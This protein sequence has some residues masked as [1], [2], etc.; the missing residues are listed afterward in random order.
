[1]RPIRLAM[2]A[3]GPYASKIELNLEQLGTGGLY[4]ITGDTGAGKTTIFDA[5]TF[6]LYGEASGENREASML[7]SKYAQPGTPTEVE[8]T[9]SY[10]GKEY[11]VKR[12]PEYERP[13]ARGEGFTS[14]K[15]DARFRYPDGRMV[16]GL[17]D[18]NR[19]VLQTLGIDRAQFT[20]IAMI[21]QGDFLKLLFASTED[22]K[23]IFQK[24][25]RTERYHTL[26]ERLKDESGQLKRERDDLAN[27]IGQYM[28]DIR[29]DGDEPLSRR[30]AGEKAFVSAEGIREILALLKELI[31]RDQERDEA[32]EK[33]IGQLD[34]RI[35][36]NTA[37][38]ARAQAWAS[39]GK[40][41]AEASLELKEGE[42]SLRR[43]D[44]AL[45]AEE[46]R[47][48]RREKIRTQAITIGEQ[49]PDYTE[50]DRLLAERKAAGKALEDCRK[51]LSDEAAQKEALERETEALQRERRELEDA[52]GVRAALLAGRQE[53]ERKLERCR[54]LKEALEEL[55]GLERELERRRKACGKKWETSEK[56][57]ERYNDMFRRYLSEQAGILAQALQ[58]GQPCPVCGSVS[59]PKTAV[60]SGNAPTKAELDACREA[61]ER[62]R[63]DAAAAGEEAAGLLG[64]QEQKRQS[65]ESDLR[66]LLGELPMEEASRVLAETGEQTKGQL[67]LLQEKIRTEDERIRRREEVD[68]LLSGKA[69]MRQ[70]L[71]E[72]VRFAAE[73]M[74]EKETLLKTFAE[75]TEVLSGKLPFS[76]AAQA[77]REKQALEEQ[78][79]RM[80]ESLRK[81]DQDVRVQREK[82]ARHKARIEEAQ[83]QLA[84]AQE[85]D[86]QEA[87]RRRL[88][89]KEAR[90][91]EGGSQKTI[92]ARWTHN[93]AILE[94]LLR[95]LDQLSGVEERWQWVKALSDT[96][97]G[98]LSGREKIML[99]TYVQ[100]ACFDRIIDRSNLRF[101]EM[102]GGQYELKRRREAGNNR[103][104]SGLELDVIDHYNGTMRSVKTLSGGEAFKA[105]LSLALGLADEIQS[106]AGGIRLDTMFVDE[107]FGSLDEDSLE[108]AVKALLEL[109]QGN[110]LVGIISH[111]GALKE[112]I[113]RQIV[114]IKGKSGGSSVRIIGC[115]IFDSA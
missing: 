96:A 48:P 54:L 3:F 94:N 88:Q 72:A 26:Q 81:A 105:S 79:C 28:D 66:L 46:E 41:L 111:V 90:E 5:I 52:E 86:T 114:V 61:M 20:Q 6:A 69:K 62:A 7:R 68:K 82:N 17:K 16:T 108:Q 23:K 43:F 13:K 74:G 56:E 115:G 58:D 30:T 45:Q 19:A 34:Q 71:E 4:L 40:S 89:L 21:A 37:L 10:A 8:L 76:S 99:E 109:T 65:V 29:W 113:D 18:V 11:F 91:A 55:A 39:A 95:K 93:E 44:A 60:K 51:A 36:E 85:V 102:S 53:A 63:E 14:E 104:Q 67:T 77:K 31:R 75:R 12:N 9:F 25:F 42:A 50:L 38:L 59:H 57:A 87:E 101:M 35:E 70:A 47:T 84:Q 49:L 103:S 110:R 80:E 32:L 78:L 112:R 92:H 33:R 106:F 24:I 15:A 83:K 64:K 27:G 98:S 22:R 97:N 2:S 100:T 73:Q 107:G 1:M